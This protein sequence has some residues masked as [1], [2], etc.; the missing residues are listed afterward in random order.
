MQVPA[1][2]SALLVNTA[3]PPLDDKNL[4]RAL[5]LATDR[6]AISDLI[7]FNFSPIAWAPLS[8][9]TGYTHTGYVGSFAYDLAAAKELI[10]AAGFADSDGDGFV[11]R[12]GNA[13]TLHMVVPP[14]DQLPQ[15]AEALRRAWR[16]AGIDLRLEPVPGK[17]RLTELILSGEYDLL[18]IDA[19]G[20]DPVILGQVFADDSPYAASRAPHPRLSQL[21][22][23][24]EREID[25]QL[26]RERYYELQALLMNETL[27]LPL[28]EPL[29]LTATRAA[30][31][32]L[33]YDAYGLYPLL[34]NVAMQ[35]N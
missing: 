20:I 14:G 13:L 10:A 32:N 29:R 11:E 19:A 34:H 7:T 9:S 28:R 31:K 18:P 35:G 8:T 4:R 12:D 3:R 25:R 5:L 1:L 33:R 26:R 15:I 23:Q 21:L 16:S 24:A 2:A 22:L 30:V 17:S 27:I 6:A